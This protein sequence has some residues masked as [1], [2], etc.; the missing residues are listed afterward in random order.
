MTI[1]Q[2]VTRDDASTASFP[3]STSQLFSYNI[4][5]SILYSIEKKLGSGVGGSGTAEAF[6]HDCKGRV[7]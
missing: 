2:H 3:G 6:L 4:R 1:S 7:V 5:H